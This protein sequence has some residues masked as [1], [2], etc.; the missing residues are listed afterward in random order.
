MCRFYN[1]ECDKFFCFCLLLRFR[2]KKN[3]KFQSATRFYHL[4]KN[5]KKSFFK[6]FNGSSTRKENQYRKFV[7]K[8]SNMPNARFSSLTLN[9]FISECNDLS[10]I[11]NIKWWHTKLSH[12]YNESTIKQSLPKR[13]YICFSHSQCLVRRAKLRS[14]ANFH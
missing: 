12:T 10:L 4:S 13:L 7:L 5:L 6:M 14:A 2:I 11:T 3:Q 8:R 9:H 1:D